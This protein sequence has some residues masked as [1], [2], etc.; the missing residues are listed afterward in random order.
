MTFARRSV[1]ALLLTLFT[2]AVPPAL[3]AVERL[4]DPT[5][6]IARI[7]A[8]QRKMLLLKMEVKMTQA[9]AKRHQRGIAARDVLDDFGPGRDLRGSRAAVIEAMAEAKVERRATRPA[10]SG[11]RPVLERVEPDPARLTAAEKRARVAGIAAAAGFT[12]PTNIRVND[13]TGDSA[14]DGQCEVDLAVDGNNLVVAWNDGTGFSDLTGDTQGYGYSTNG[15]A[16]FTDGGKLPTPGAFPNFIWTSDP[17]VTVNE[18]T[19]EFWYA[20]L[21]SPS[22]G[23][24]GIAVVKGT[25]AGSNLNWG[26]PV[27]V[28]SV[29]DAQFF[30][31]KLWMVADS[32]SGNLYLTYTEFNV[33][34]NEINLR[35]STDGGA[36]W[37]GDIKINNSADDGLVQGSRPAVGPGGQVHVAFYAIGAA[38]FDHMKFAVSIN[39]GVSFNTPGIAVSFAPNFGTGAPGFNR[40]M[41]IQF[42][43]IAVD[44]TTGPNRGRVYMAWNETVDWLGETINFGTGKY[45]VEPNSGTGN[46]TPITIGQPVR[47][48]LSS[49]T[50][51]NDYFSF[52]ATA[53]TSYIF[54]ADSLNAG[55]LYTMRIICT[56]GTNQLAFSGDTQFGGSDG[57][58]VWTAPANGTY[59][60]RMA[61]LPP[62]GSNT[63]TTG[64]YRVGTKVET[65]GA[66][67]GRDTRDVFVTSSINNGLSWSLPSR[68]NDDAALYDN[69]LPEIEVGGNGIPYVIW[70]DW[71][72]SAPNCG[73]LSHVYL[74]RS[75]NTGASWVSLGP[76]TSVQSDWTNVSSN[77]APNQGDYLGLFAD[78]NSVYPTWSDGRDGDPDI[79]FSDWPLSVTPVQISLAT[80]SA[81]PDRVDISWFAGG[82]PLNE[83]I[84]QRRTETS[85]WQSLATLY[86]DGTSRFAFTDEDVT[87]G[88]RYAYRLEIVDE[89]VTRFVG[90]T[91]VDVPAAAHL[92]IAGI[93]PNPSRRDAWVTFSLAS[94]ARATLTL[95][96]I[97]GRV[98]REREV[99]SLGAGSHQLNLGA[100]G[101]LEAG[102]YLVRITQ[103]EN[104]VT[105]RMSVV[106]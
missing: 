40:E 8:H 30:L 58:I 70:Y 103:G 76:V 32:A 96:D 33:T 72:D 91:W 75:D 85:D 45:E 97:A 36:T 65:P 83:A 4:S 77:I 93:R 13:R 27:V 105:S 39:G 20:G 64:G 38:N 51:E 79:Y 66:G 1:F 15:G 43:A 41:G 19:G 26:T 12:P 104:S 68:V 50:G 52:S 29:S 62:F 18:E 94:G 101:P 34:G 86:V 47:G 60:F 24:N 48:F 95:L 99:G 100:D 25:F 42:P 10:G 73:G 17:I 16:S 78:E 55:L 31:D 92:A 22:V 67:R 80:V 81:K 102:V 14:S 11:R 90:E 87:P 35:R 6:T 61:N 57:F 69:W 63:F 98:V 54:W 28:R 7:R 82:D 71:R 53:G 9:L 37:G 56:N 44:R 2:A 23:N 46:A 89:G 88:S 106:R 49:T 21:C 5:E 84:V 3:P 59:Y 74:A